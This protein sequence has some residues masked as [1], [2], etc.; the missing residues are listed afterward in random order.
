MELNNKKIYFASDFHLGNVSKEHSRLREKKIVEWLKYVSKD[1]EEIYLLGD[2]FDF[3]FEY[4]NVV[5]KGFVRFLGTLADIADSGVKIHFFCGNHD[6]WIRD[7]FQ[8]ELGIIVHHQ[9]ETINLHGKTFMI[10]H[11]DGLDTKDK[12]YKFINSIF[13][14]KFCIS[15]F[16]SLHPRLAIP[17]AQ[18]WS[19]SSRASHSEDDKKDLGEQEPIYKY[20]IKAL[21]KEH[22]DFFVFGHRH[23][24]CDKAI[25][26]SSRYVN[27]GYWDKSGHYAVWD[28][29]NLTLKKFD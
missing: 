27:L 28:G 3:W 16:A 17:L 22:I 4:N 7:Y 11:G 8:D 23:L 20:C 29:E 21:E 10:G 9:K 25:T 6:L 15:L 18:S 1:A 19:K 12:K 13:K 26:N 2:I 24:V 14:N 5:P